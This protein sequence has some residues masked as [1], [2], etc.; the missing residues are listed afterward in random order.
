MNPCDQLE[1]LFH[2][3]RRLAIVSALCS[4]PAGLSFADLKRTCQLTDG[5]LN[6]H[7]KALQTAQAVDIAKTRT[8]TRAITVIALT[9]TGRSG[10]LSYLATLEDVLEQAIQALAPAER[11]SM[12]SLP[13]LPSTSS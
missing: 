2:E 9:E 12:A 7:L 8:D 5:N 1:K 10:F 6:R 11:A 13:P 3:P 4:E